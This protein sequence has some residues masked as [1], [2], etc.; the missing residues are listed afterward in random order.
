MKE[1]AEYRLYA[2]FSDG[3]GTYTSNWRIANGAAVRELL[4][5]DEMYFGWQE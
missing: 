2:F 3:A 5:N 4:S 1:G